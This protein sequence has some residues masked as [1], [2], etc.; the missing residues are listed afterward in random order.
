YQSTLDRI[1]SRMKRAI[2]LL[3]EAVRAKRAASAA[4]SWS[5]LAAMIHADDLI[6]LAA[7]EIKSLKEMVLRFRG[8]AAYDQKQQQSDIV[9]KTLELDR[10]EKQVWLSKNANLL[11]PPEQI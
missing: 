1:L 7:Q 4:S 6:A 8:R 5:A 3:T 9:Q 2:K 11:P 10:I